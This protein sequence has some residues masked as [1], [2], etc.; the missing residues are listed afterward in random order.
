MLKAGDIVSMAV[1]VATCSITW[2]RNG[3]IVEAQQ[4]FKKLQD[5]S[6]KW[7]PYIYLGGG[8]SVILLEETWT[9]EI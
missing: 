2:K 1:D 9:L 8:H 6:I 3:A 4:Q 5:T 7:V